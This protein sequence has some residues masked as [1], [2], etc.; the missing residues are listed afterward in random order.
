MLNSRVL[1][2]ETLPIDG[3]DRSIVFPLEFFVQACDL[4]GLE[5]MFMHLYV[6]AGGGVG[7]W[8]GVMDQ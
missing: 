7:G 8:V 2:E 1:T 3:T 4:H 6:F 5:N